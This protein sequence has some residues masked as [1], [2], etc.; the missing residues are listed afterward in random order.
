MT[1][2]FIHHENLLVFSQQVMMEMG[3]SKEDSFC[4]ADNLVMSNLRG[5]DSHGVGRLKRYVEG[6]RTG[7]ILP[8]SQPIVEK[9]SL[10]IAN[11]NAMC[12]RL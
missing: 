11:I 1:H 4:V 5:I 6:I 10:V 3:A 9:E 7:Y 8:E 12:H 2:R